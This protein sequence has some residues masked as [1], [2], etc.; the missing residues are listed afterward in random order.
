MKITKLVK[1]LKQL[2]FKHKPHHNVPPDIKALIRQAFSEK[3]SS[4]SLNKFCSYLKPFNLSPSTV[5]SIIYTWNKLPNPFSSLSWINH[6]KSNYSNRY[7]KSSRKPKLLSFS[8]QQINFIKHLR[9]NNP[10]M[11]YK[12]FLNLLLVPHFKSKYHKLFWNYILSYRQFYSIINHFNLPKA[13]SKRQKINLIRKLKKSNSLDPYLSKMKFTYTSF[14]ALH[15]WQVDIKYLSDIPNYI[16]LWLNNIYL[17]QITFRDFKSWL[18]L[19]FYWNNRDKSRVFVSFLIFKFLLKLVWINP[20]L[21]SVQM[22][23]W[24]EF[25]N[26]KINWSKWPLINFIESNFKWFSIIKRKEHNWHVEAFHNLIEKHFFDTKQ[27]A[28]LKNL[29]KS[30]KDK[31]I[32]LP[33]IANYIKQF[34]KYWYSSYLPRYKTFGKKSPIQIIK[35]DL[36]NSVRVDLIEKYFTAYDVDCV[37]NM[38]KKYD[39]ISLLS[40]TIYYNENFVENQGKSSIL[41]SNFVDFD[42]FASLFSTGQIWADGYIFFLFDFENNL[43]INIFR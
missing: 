22:D 33:L 12:S 18:S 24:A 37:F 7:S 32:I 26:I 43:N 29:I 2:W 17:Y 31:S 1:L 4:M 20:K 28:D 8:N 39:Y 3:S 27:V 14:K 6:S 10:S 16:Q 15:H 35:E 13:K 25:S 40:C 41:K 30:K 19:V 34:N 36:W 38:K 42:Y 5:K 23:W 21:V 9:I 11:G